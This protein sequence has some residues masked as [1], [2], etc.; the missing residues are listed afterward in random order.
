MSCGEL[1]N[2][3]PHRVNHPHSLRLRTPPWMLADVC[4]AYAPSLS[5]TSSSGWLIS[6]PPLSQISFDAEA[7]GVSLPWI[8]AQPQQRC[9]SSRLKHGGRGHH[10]ARSQ[11][12]PRAG[13]LLWGEEAPFTHLYT[14][15]YVVWVKTNN[16][17]K[18]INS[19]KSYIS[20][21]PVNVKV[22]VCRLRKHFL[23][24][25]ILR[26][27]PKYGTHADVVK[28]TN[29]TKVMFTR[30]LIHKQKWMNVGLLTQSD[31]SCWHVALESSGHSLT[32]LYLAK[33]PVR[34]CA[35]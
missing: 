14:F 29:P 30:L 22:S 15:P 28:N 11:Q 6:L 27:F 35:A 13:L 3:T 32:S 24:I 21:S 26:F 5:S 10:Q 25:S 12:H 7:E 8:T 1:V 4:R 20:W 33:G 9:G 34:W 19:L 17:I 16:F 2:P 18:K 23:N 31:Q